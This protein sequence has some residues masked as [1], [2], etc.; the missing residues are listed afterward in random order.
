MASAASIPAMHMPH[1]SVNTLEYAALPYLSSQ[2]PMIA[3]RQISGRLKP[4]MDAT[5]IA[6]PEISF[7]TFASSTEAHMTPRAMKQTV[8]RT[9]VSTVKIVTSEEPPFTREM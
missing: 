2:L 8:A 7:G 3:G 6:V 4:T 5:A 9:S 1:S